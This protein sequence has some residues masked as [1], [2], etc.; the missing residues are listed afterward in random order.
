MTQATAMLATFFE[1]QRD[2]ELYFLELDDRCRNFFDNLP[3]EEEVE[4][5]VD[6]AATATC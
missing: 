1:A 3:G 2:G 6:D 5:V 4:L